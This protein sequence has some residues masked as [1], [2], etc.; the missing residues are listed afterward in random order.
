MTKAKRTRLKA[1]ETSTLMTHEL[2]GGI[3]SDGEAVNHIL[4]KD[5]DGFLIEIVDDRIAKHVYALLKKDAHPARFRKARA[6]AH[7]K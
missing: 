6:L 3:S 2:V 4:R 7:K 5:C 1:A